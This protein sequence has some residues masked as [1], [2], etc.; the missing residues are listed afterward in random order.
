[1]QEAIL[2]SLPINLCN[3]LVSLSCF[4]F[5]SSL[6]LWTLILPAKFLDTIL[7][8]NWDRR[9]VDT[10][11]EQPGD[12]ILFHISLPGRL[13]LPLLLLILLLL[14]GSSFSSSS[15]FSFF[16][17]HSNLRYTTECSEE[18]RHHWGVYKGACCFSSVL[19]WQYLNSLFYRAPQQYACLDTVNFAVRLLICLFIYLSHGHDTHS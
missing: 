11:Q 16:L 19:C 3:Q 9:F 17:L 6:N 12:S 7:H 18:L 4:H 1:M 10:H 15:S 5:S 14:S 13:L 8:S 2:I